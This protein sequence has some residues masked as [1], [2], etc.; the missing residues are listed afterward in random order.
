MRV[1]IF[2]SDDYMAV[3]QGP[4][5]HHM[6]LPLLNCGLDI[7]SLDFSYNSTG[8][9][10]D[11]A[12][13]IEVTRHFRPDVI[14]Y[15]Q[16]GYARNLSTDTFARIRAMGA[17]II[18]AI[19]DTTTI[20]DRHTL[21]LFD[22]CDVFLTYDA[23]Y[24]FVE[25]ALWSEMAHR[26]S[27]RVYF[28]GGNFYTGVV[29]PATAG[30]IH[31]VVFA[32]SRTGI[33]DEFLTKVAAG[34]AAEGIALTQV[35]GVVGGPAGAADDIPQASPSFLPL[36]DF[37]GALQ[38]SRIVLNCQSE[39]Y[40]EQVKGR[41]Y[42]T[43]ACG[44]LCLTDR[45]PDVDLMFPS[46][47]IETYASPEEC[48]AKICTLL[49]DEPRRAAIAARGKAWFDQNLNYRAFWSALLLS[50]TGSNIEV[51]QLK[52][53]VEEL[54]RTRTALSLV[55][56]QFLHLIR[57]ARD[58]SLNGLTLRTEAP[59]LTVGSLMSTHPEIRGHIDDA[60]MGIGF[61]SGPLGERAAMLAGWGLLKE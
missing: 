2:N 28:P 34:L 44:S 54:D 37:F 38:R 46:D 48:V 60:T 30:L 55:E 21:Q 4:H 59:F 57:L 51:P 1:L 49:A 10:I 32:G 39:P 35:G 52:I 25:F 33:R 5:N 23:I 42:E 3:E 26:G 13:A 24:T 9:G 50:T 47:A 45:R 40:R 11:E 16:A 58:L 8:A 17:P 31:D 14:V 19:Y 36:A 41:I 18:C 22:A 56:P 61:F 20:K 15:N 53:L 29:P 7:E 6:R 43:L 12:G 27:K